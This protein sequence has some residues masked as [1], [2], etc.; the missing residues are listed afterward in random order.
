[1]SVCINILDIS[2]RYVVDIDFSVSKRYLKLHIT[3]L[4]S[5]SILVSLSFFSFCI[6]YI[7]S[8]ISRLFYSLCDII[9]IK[10]K[11]AFNSFMTETVVI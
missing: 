9:Q 1:M 4:L 5:R 6:F 7:I 2:T 3:Y 10:L 8:A 11:Y